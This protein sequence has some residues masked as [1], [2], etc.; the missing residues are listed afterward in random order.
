MSTKNT[1]PNALITLGDFSS[2]F[3]QTA[4]GFIALSDE[5]KEFV[6]MSSAQIMALLRS[7]PTIVQLTD[8]SGD[9]VGFIIP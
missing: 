1:D 4:D 6:Q 9:T 2:H 3:A 8:M 7:D 5:A